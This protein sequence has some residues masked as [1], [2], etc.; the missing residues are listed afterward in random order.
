MFD[1]DLRVFTFC[2]NQCRNLGKSF[3]FG[4]FEGMVLYVGIILLPITSAMDKKKKARE[5]KERECL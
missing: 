5:K 4:A 1:L 3:G 2:Y